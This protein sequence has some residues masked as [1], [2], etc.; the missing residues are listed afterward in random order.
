[1]RARE[2]AAPFVKRALTGPRTVYHVAVRRADGSLEDPS[3][4]LGMK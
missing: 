2:R 4:L 1:V 3:R